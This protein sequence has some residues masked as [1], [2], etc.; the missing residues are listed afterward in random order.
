MLES[1]RDGP[2][3]LEPPLR[4]ATHM[5]STTVGCA[6]YVHAVS[7]FQVFFRL[8]QGLAWPPHGA[9]GPG[10]VTGVKSRRPPR[11]ARRAWRR[12]RLCCGLTL[13]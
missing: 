7:F 6:V 4:E 1:A 9:G 11:L 5:E 10:L 12:R 13:G 8:L 2:D 3:I